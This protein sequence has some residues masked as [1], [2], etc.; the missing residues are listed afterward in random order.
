MLVGINP[1]INLTGKSSDYRRLKRSD[2][3]FEAGLGCDFYLPYFKL[4]PEL[5]FLYGLSNCLD[6]NHAKNIRDVSR[7][8]YTNSVSSACS[9]MIVFSFYF[10]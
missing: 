8:P 7:L 3:F 6:P 2:V 5:K 10:E 4:R 1:M 9:K